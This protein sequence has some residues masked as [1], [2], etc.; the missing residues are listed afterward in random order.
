MKGIWVKLDTRGLEEV[1]EILLKSESYEALQMLNN[2]GDKFLMRN[3]WELKIKCND[4]IFFIKCGQDK[5]IQDDEYEC[6]TCKVVF[7]KEPGTDE[8]IREYLD[9]GEKLSYVKIICDD[10][11]DLEVNK[12]NKHLK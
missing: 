11:Y 9:D 2:D 3:E 8:R 7:K 4:I 6:D 5:W 12:E 1:M 10:C